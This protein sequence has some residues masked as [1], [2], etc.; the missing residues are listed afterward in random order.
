MNRTAGQD[1]VQCFSTVNSIDLLLR[2]E[3]EAYS[4]Q[5]K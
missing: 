5:A 1:R 3:S 4:S 2:D